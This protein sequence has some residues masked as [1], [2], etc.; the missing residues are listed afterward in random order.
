MIYKNGRTGDAE[1]LHAR[2]M[3]QVE[4]VSADALPSTVDDDNAVVQ[5]AAKYQQA[6]EARITKTGFEVSHPGSK[7]ISLFFMSQGFQLV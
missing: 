6:S 4:D 3:V 1:M 5:G 2:D 7:L